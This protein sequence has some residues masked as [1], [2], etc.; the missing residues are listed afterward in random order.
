MQVTEVM[1]RAVK[2]VS[3]DQR[4]SEAAEVMER[5][6]VGVL[7]VMDQDRLVGMIT[8]R[9]IAVRSTSYGKDP[10]IARV[11][12]VATDRVVYCHDDADLR[13]VATI[14]AREN[15]RRLPVLHQ[16]S[17]RLVGLV[18]VDDIIDKVDDKALLAELFD[19]LRPLAA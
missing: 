6:N 16:G 19:S 12:D 1:N 8:D 9:D 7:P 14:M 18:S 11:V 15:V 2:V 4:V 5:E 10:L 13:E 3:P 17:E